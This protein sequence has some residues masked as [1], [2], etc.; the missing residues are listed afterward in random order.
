MTKKEQIA[1]LV[2]NKVEIIEMKK[3]RFKM[4]DSCILVEATPSMINKALTTDASKDTADVIKRTII[5]NTYNWLDSH[6]DVHLDNTFSKS[7]KERGEKGKI[8][9]LH[10]HEQKVTAKIGQPLKVYEKLVN[11]T[12]LGVQKQGMTTALM[13]DSNVMKSYNSLMFEEYKNGNIDQ[14]SVGMYYVKV[15]LAVNDPDFPEEYKEWTEHINKLGNK[16]VAEELGF[17]W[18]VKEAKL[19][20]ISAVLEG[21]NSLT[22]TLEAKDIQPSADTDKEP[23]KDTQN[24]AKDKGSNAH[25]ITFYKNL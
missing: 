23:S 14:H 4:A 11:W 24:H 25:L 22:P 9:H 18:A 15:D 10:D 17:F 5:G 3:A 2:R 6:G 13:M 12:D 1:Q 8:W 21:S 20:E 7:I 16:E 19:I